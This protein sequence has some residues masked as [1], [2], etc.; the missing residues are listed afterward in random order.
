MKSFFLYR[1]PEKVHEFSIKS[2]T[3]REKEPYMESVSADIDENLAYA[4]AVFSY[5]KN[6]DIIIREFDVD[7]TDKPIRAF[8]VCADGLSDS[9]LINDSVL[10]PLMCLSGFSRRSGENTEE[11][12]MRRLIPHV[13]LSRETDVNRALQAVNY[14]DCAVFADTVGAAFVIDTKSWGHREVGEPVNETVVQGPHEG[15]NE[16]FRSNTALIRKTLNTSSLVMENTSLGKTSR[17]PAAIC[18]LK[19]V[20]NS[21]LVDEVRYRTENIDAEYILSSLALAQY[22]E[23][24]TFLPFPQLVATE[25]PDRVCNALAEGRAAVVVGGSPQVLIMPT[26]VF[27]AA[28]SPEDAYLRFPYSFLTRLI[29]IAAIALALLAPAVFLAVMNF[30]RELILT[31]ILFA[32]SNARAA[33]PFPSLTELLL[34]ELSFELIKEAG[35]RVPGPAGSA[36]GIVG[37]LILGQAAVSANIVSPITIIVVAVAGIASFAIPNYQLAFSVRFMRFIYTL[38]AAWGG[39]FG[40]FAVMFIDTVLIVNAKSFGA[41]YAQPLAPKRKTNLLALIF[42]RP[43]WKGGKRPEYPEPK[44]KYDAA[45][46]SRKWKYRR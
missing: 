11:Y 2:G 19:N 4:R 38:A 46:I 24:G 8:A 23:E 16:M 39:F 45:K 13:S 5:P 9:A 29:R 7:V 12:L 42:S 40:I 14:G 15:F 30:H 35:I 33:V 22:I 20:A 44:D 6:G 18:Y 28:V 41:P 34:M 32:L 3:E 31:D 1:E 25:R 10:L 27:D 43:V 26:T 36:L 37:G 17:T 21:S